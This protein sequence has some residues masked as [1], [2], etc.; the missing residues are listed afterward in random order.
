MYELIIYKNIPLATALDL[1]HI[2]GVFTH[3]KKSPAKEKL[4]Y[5]YTMPTVIIHIA[6]NCRVHEGRCIY[7]IS[8]IYSEDAGSPNILNADLSLC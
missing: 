6:N 5:K 8:I 2:L 3:V 4:S 1:V 7:E